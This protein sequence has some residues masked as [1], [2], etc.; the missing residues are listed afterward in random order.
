MRRR[1][2]AT[3]RGGRGQSGRR[4]TSPLAA[5]DFPPL[6]G[7]GPSAAGASSGSWASIVGGGASAS[8]PSSPSLRF[9]SYNVLAQ[10][11]L[12]GNAQNYGTCAADALRA[13]LR[14]PRVLAAAVAL[15][16][17]VVGMQEVEE[18]EDV[19]VPTLAAHGY[20]GAYK[21]RTGAE[22]TD[23]CA[24]FWRHETLELEHLEAIEMRSLAE[25]VTP[26]DEAQ[27]LRKDNVALLGVFRERRSG[28]R[29]V[30]GC[31]HVLW[32]PSRG[33]REAPADP[34]VHAARGGARV[35]RRRCRSSS[36]T[37]TAR[38]ARSCTA[39]SSTARSPPS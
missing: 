4:S 7:G 27:R 19:F 36:A 34:E 38:R 29:V 20:R 8:A 32:N 35:G 23:G 10:S 28:R 25:G 12:E 1:A 18:F 37:S 3:G 39:F 11:L 22:K 9:A 2:L 16:A 13:E 15:D 30:V 17:D 21:Q 31:L 24:L 5:D 26:A 33:L 14:L 6:G